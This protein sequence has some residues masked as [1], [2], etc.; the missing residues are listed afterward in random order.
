MLHGMRSAALT[1]IFLAVACGPGEETLLRSVTADWRGEE[2]GGG[3]RIQLEQG[4]GMLIELGPDGT[5]RDTMLVE[6]DRVVPDSRTV[7]LR[8]IE[9]EAPFTV[10]LLEPAEDGRS[11]IR[12]GFPSGREVPLVFQRSLSGGSS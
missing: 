11:R 8:R 6:V 4:E 5:P 12:L 10:E 3:I 1:G 2:V 9:T 7:Y